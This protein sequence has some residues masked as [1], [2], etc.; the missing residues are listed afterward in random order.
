MPWEFQSAIPG[1]AWPA[2]PQHS[3]NATLALLLQL[4]GTERLAPERL[5][6]ERMRQLAALVRHAWQSVPHYRE[7]WAGAYDPTLPFSAER[8]LALPLLTRAA[9][10]ERYEALKSRAYPAE[11][12]SASE[13]SSSG[14]TGA[15]VRIMA[16]GVTRLFWEAITL[17]DHAWHRRH[18]S[19]KLA[20]IRRGVTPGTAPSWGKATAGLVR[21]GEAVMLDVDG[22]I[23]SQLDWLERQA[24]AYLL[25][26]PSLAAELAKASLERGRGLP[27]LLQVRTLGESLAPDLRALCREAWGVPVADAYS[28]EEVGY[29]ALQCPEHEHYHV[30][31]ESLLVEVLDDD[32][33]ACAPGQAGRVVL[34]DLHNFA[35]P[36]IRYDI[37]DYAEP[38][39]ACACGRTLPVLKRI[40]G[41]VRNVLVAPDGRRYWPA[42]GSRA[43]AE[44][45]AVR[46]HQ[47]VQTARDRV[48]VRLVVSAPLSAD[49]EERLRRHVLSRMPAGIGLELSYRDRIPR[50]AGGKYEEF[51]SAVA[52]A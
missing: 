43:L 4:E 1:F 15:P 6:R 14:S 34:T 3:A 10:R 48:E 30:Q 39:E 23:G 29:I 31:A 24:P 37:G 35:T 13:T 36:L 33:A 42:F 25:T 28:A 46:Q 41:R 21:T 32:G 26:Y 40:L 8:L 49:E 17:R 19:G 20:V 50:G 12:G 5:E 45:G 52:T 16:T 9:L 27:G 2:I 22:D 11:Q 7:A 38:G 18:L 51:L 47:L 44:F